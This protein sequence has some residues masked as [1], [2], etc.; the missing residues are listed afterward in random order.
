M[1]ISIVSTFVVNSP[2]CKSEK[3]IR[4]YLPRK[5]HLKLRSDIFNKI[6]IFNIKPFKTIH[7]LH[8]KLKNFLPGIFIENRNMMFFDPDSADDFAVFECKIF[9]FLKI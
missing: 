1:L 6:L 8:K 2:Y 9:F 4:H 3:F 5:L 7:F